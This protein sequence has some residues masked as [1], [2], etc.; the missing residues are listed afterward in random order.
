MQSSR[1]GISYLTEECF[2]ETSLDFAGEKQ[3]VVYY[4]FGNRTELD[5][6]RTREGTYLPGSYWTH[7]PLETSPSTDLHNRMGHVI[8]NIEVP[9]DLEQGEYIL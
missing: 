1:W 6:K 8:D 9:T 3:W 7:N 5:A 4:G 2:Q